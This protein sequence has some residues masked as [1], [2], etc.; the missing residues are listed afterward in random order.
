MQTPQIGSID[1]RGPVHLNTEVLD[2]PES[3]EGSVM[4]KHDNSL[5]NIDTIIQ[6]SPYPP[7]EVSIKSPAA[8]DRV[9]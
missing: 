8:I 5:Y 7:E 4:K 6:D 3:V 1:A 2:T 9:F